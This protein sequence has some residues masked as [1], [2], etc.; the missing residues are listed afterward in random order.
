MPGMMSAT[1]SGER[2]APSSDTLPGRSARQAAGLTQPSAQ[3]Q[4]SGQNAG[5]FPGQ[6]PGQSPGR[7]SRQRQATGRPGAKPSQPGRSRRFL[8]AA[9]VL[10]LIV[11][12]AVGY[13]ILNGRGTASAGIVRAAGRLEVHEFPVIS[14]TAA[15]LAE[16]SVGEGEMVSEGQVLARLDL[17]Q[18]KGELSHA[19][20]LIAQTK[21][22]LDAAQAEANQRRIQFQ[23]AD[24]EL[25]RWQA[26][27]VVTRSQIDQRQA[28]RDAAQ[29]T[30][31][32][33]AADESA[34]EQ[35]YDA[36][37]KDADKLRAALNDDRIVAP[38]DG[39]VQ[40]RLAEVGE[41]VAR[42]GP[43]LTMVDPSDVTLALNLPAADTDGV[44]PGAEARVV[45][46]GAPNVPF[47]ATVAFVGARIATPGAATGAAT[48]AV[49]D[50]QRARL[51]IAPDLA[52]DRQ[53][54][55]RTGMAAVGYIATRPNTEWPAALRPHT[56]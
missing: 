53:G 46:D 14:A 16:I 11:A 26:R 44:K 27:A 50:T 12:G 2:T 5:Q 42:G 38:R 35:A 41:T 23:A 49:T 21:L 36:A 30:L 43:V 20:A 37:R 45:L 55:L 7:S 52:H 22:A 6:P 10:A 8:A 29:T 3:G 13:Y 17:S 47:A 56:P 4:A 9:V 19:E 54:E 51:H 15:P 48:G 1:R 18:L 25:K 24:G 39:R 40:Y 31:T 33:A 34:T 32:A 28:V